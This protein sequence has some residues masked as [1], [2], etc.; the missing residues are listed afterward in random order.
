MKTGIKK[1]VVMV[2]EH[3][4]YFREK[5][6]GVL[7]RYENVSSVILV[8]RYANM[9]E[10][11]RNSSPDLLFV[12]IEI[13]SFDFDSIRD[14]KVSDPDTTIIVYTDNPKNECR[15]AALDSGADYF[16][17]QSQITGLMEAIWNEK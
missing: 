13:A 11:V 5:L 9:L 15:Q 10:A 8:S 17:K 7:S 1:S 4:D 12:N 16:S 14:I 6:S 3:N 2:A